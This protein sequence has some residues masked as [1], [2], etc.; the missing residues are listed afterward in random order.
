MSELEH[1][2]SCPVAALVVSRPCQLAEPT[3]LNP[4]NRAAAD[5]QKIEDIEREREEERERG[6]E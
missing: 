4:S 6:R 2:G 3:E 5:R 1:W